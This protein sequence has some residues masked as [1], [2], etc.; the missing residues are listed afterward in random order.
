[1]ADRLRHTLLATTLGL[2]L[3]TGLAWLV[4]H[5]PAPFPWKIVIGMTTVF[6]V[7]GVLGGRRWACWVADFF[8]RSLP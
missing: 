6:A 8:N 2:V 3:G 7:C 1:M 4:H 5:D